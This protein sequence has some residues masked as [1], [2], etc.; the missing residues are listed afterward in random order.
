MNSKEVRGRMSDRYK[1]YTEA[2]TDRQM[3]L[4]L[5][6][7]LAASS[8]SLR[9]DEYGA[10]RITGSNGHIYTWGDGETWVMY[11]ASGST[12]KWAADKKK[13]GFCHVTQD[14]EDNGCLRLL[15][16]PTAVQAP[17]IPEV[18][19]IRKRRSANQGSYG[20]KTAKIL[21]E[22]PEPEAFPAE[23]HA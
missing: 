10:W 16:L 14:G 2:A 22:A 8:L 13:L 11:V 17:I 4:T 5:I 19:G 23:I 9:R 12:R 21:I 18:L 1:S 3:Q 20:S 7:A 6:E 15:G